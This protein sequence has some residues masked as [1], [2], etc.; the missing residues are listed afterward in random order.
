MIFSCF[1]SFLLSNSFIVSKWLLASKLR[2]SQKELK[3]DVKKL[4]LIKTRGRQLFWAW[5]SL[6]SIP[7]V[8]ALCLSE[9]S[10]VLGWSTRVAFFRPWLPYLYCFGEII[11]NDLHLFGDQVLWQEF[12]LKGF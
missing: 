8:K 4:V 5:T 7:N 11:K 1:P 3:A 2:L 12:C 10:E 6:Q 9:R